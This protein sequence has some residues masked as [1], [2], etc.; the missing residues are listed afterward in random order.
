MPTEDQFFFEMLSYEL[1]AVGPAC[2]RW[3][4]RAGEIALHEEL[5][6]HLEKDWKRLRRK[7]PKLWELVRAGIG[8]GTAESVP[9]E[10][11]HEEYQLC[12]VSVQQVVRSLPKPPTPKQLIDALVSRPIQHD[13]EDGLPPIQRRFLQT[14]DLLDRLS[15]VADEGYS[16]PSDFAYALA[17]ARFA[18]PTETARPLVT[19]KGKSE[20]DR[21]RVPFQPLLALLASVFSDLCKEHSAASVDAR[22][23]SFD[24]LLHCQYPPISLYYRLVYSQ[25]SDNELPAS[26]TADHLKRLQQRCLERAG[27]EANQAD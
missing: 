19:G 16:R 7:K 9:R 26:I 8:R 24:T 10:L 13:A 20:A 23:R 21:R 25:E 18:I 5:P 27:G 22:S 11:V 1:R 17:G 15:R 4:H 3:G 2:T 14:D 6:G 12:L